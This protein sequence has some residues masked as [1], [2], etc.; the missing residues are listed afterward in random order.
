MPT[1][2]LNRKVIDKLVGKKLSEDKLKDRISMLGTDLESVDDMHIHVEIFPNRPDLLS[3]QGF[4]RA[5]STFIGKKTGLQ[6]YNV[7]KS[8]LKVIVDKNVS[9][10]PYT[11][12]AI[13]KHLTFDDE[14]I[15]EIMQVQE[16][17]ATTH[18]RNR[19][20]SAYGIYPL[21]GISFPIKYTA[22]DPKKIMFQP[23]GFN[24]K[25]M[26][27]KVLTQHPKGKEYAHITKGWKE[28]PFFIDA[29]DNVMCMLPFTNSEDTGKVDENTKD[30]FIECTGIDLENV[31]VALNILC[32]TLADMGGQIYSL[33]MNYD[34][35]KFDTPDLTPRKMDIDINYANRLLGLNLKEKDINFFLGRMGFG[36][37]NG[38]VLVPAYRADILHQVDLVE[39]IAIAY[40]YENIP[41][42][43]PNITTIAAE[44]K[45]EKFK[46]KL[47]DILVGLQLLECKSY[48]LVP[49]EIQT[50][51]INYNKNPIMVLD[52]VS[53]EYNSI[54]MNVLPSLLHILSENKHHSYP[55]RLFEIG[56]VC[57]KSKEIRDNEKYKN[58]TDKDVKEEDRLAVVDCDTRVDF[59]RI[60]QVLDYLM[61][62][63]N[64]EYSIALHKEGMFIEGRIGLIMI[65]KEKVGI[66]GEVH[67]EV[68]TN[69]KIENPVACFELDIDKLFNLVK[70]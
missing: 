25:I 21:E 16:K 20:K 36:W 19:K 55:Q 65:G 31:K 22:K 39:D 68:I 53:A 64:L 24:N 52:P 29:R 54:R 38:K 8:G 3:E 32:T 26:A 13:V 30:V 10:R 41:E 44:D 6:K 67:P 34:G 12:C 48:A 46:D 56:R 57:Y 9:M 60:K 69:F 2:K 66:I 18:G 37:M 49:K 4:A 14:K 17:L 70:D 43:I 47:S 63:L 15:R 23:L 1:V 27:D 45:L 40:G 5:F 33:E 50:K 61:R 7:K 42:E 51:M 62:M 35:K 58:V 59:T 11:V 28:Y